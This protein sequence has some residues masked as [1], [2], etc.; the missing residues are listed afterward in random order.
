[1]GTAK[2]IRKARFLLELAINA[3]AATIVSMAAVA[4][5]SLSF[6]PDNLTCL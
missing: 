6:I 3:D 5:Q 4:G 2:K 1:M